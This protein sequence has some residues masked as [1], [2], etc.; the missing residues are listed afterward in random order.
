MKLYVPVLFSQFNMTKDKITFGAF[1]IR[2]KWVR[3]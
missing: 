3:E 2:V 1:A